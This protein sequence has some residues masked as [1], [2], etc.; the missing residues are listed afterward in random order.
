[1]TVAV[2]YKIL[3]QS[4]IGSARKNNAFHQPT[5][6]PGRVYQ[7]INIIYFYG[8]VKNCSAI[9]KRVSTSWGVSRGIYCSAAWASTR[10]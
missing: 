8:V 5:R 10:L 4:A 6:L 9:R 1:M 7:L 2:I 3:V